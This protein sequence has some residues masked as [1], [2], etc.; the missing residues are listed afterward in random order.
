MNF[1]DYNDTANIGISY[2]ANDLAKSS[3]ARFY[4]TPG[5]RNSYDFDEVFETHK[6]MPTEPIYDEILRDNMQTAIEKIVEAIG[7][8]LVPIGE[9]TEREA[10]ENAR[11]IELAIT[12]AQAEADPD[13]GLPE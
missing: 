12:T 3:Y 7:M 13:F 5:S 8:R 6:E 1:P 2:H 10:E 4:Q 11:A 9:L